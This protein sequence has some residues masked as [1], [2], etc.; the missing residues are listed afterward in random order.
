MW[1]ASWAVAQGAEVKVG[2]KRP[3]CFEEKKKSVF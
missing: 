3:L 1:W 2:V